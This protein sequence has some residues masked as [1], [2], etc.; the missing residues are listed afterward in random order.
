MRQSVYIESLK[1]VVYLRWAVFFLSLLP[2]TQ[3]TSQD[4]YFQQTVNYTITVQLDD[5]NHSLSAEETIEYINHSDSALPFIWMHL[6]PNAYKDRTSALCKQLL[7]HGNGNLYFSKPEERGFIDSLDFRVNGESV[8]WEYHPDHS[9]ICKIILPLPLKPGERLILSTPFYVKIP[10]ARF[11]RLGHIGQ[12]YFITQWYP[13]PAV[14][15]AKGWH[16][17]PYLDQG[18]FYSEFG[19]FDVSIHL[20]K[21]YV[22]AATGDRADA[23]EEE[24][25]LDQL[26]SKTR[27]LI[28]NKEELKPD[29]KFPPSDTAF[30]TVRFRQNRVHDFAW[31]TDKRY[32]ALR[33]Q[34]E[35]PT[36]GRVVDTWV[37]FTPANIK[38]WKK[39][40]TYVNDAVLFYSRKL[41][42]YPY[43]HA[44]AADG[45]IMAGGGMEYPNITV[46]GTTDNDLMLD[47]TITHEVGHNWFYG[48]L[49]SN[50]RDHPY[51]DEGLNSL[52]EMLYV[53]DKYP[54]K[55][56]AELSGLG[57][58]FPLLGLNKKPYWKDK[59]L[60]Y[61]MS[62]KANLDQPIALASEEFTGFNYGAVVYSK[63]ALVF[64][65]LRDYLG[66]E[67]FDKAMG[68]YY[69][70]YRFK[71]PQPEDLFRSL[72][73]SSG[74]DMSAFEHYFINT[75]S[76]FD[77]KIKKI[78]RDENGAYT[79]VV[80]NK[81]HNPVPF[82][83]YAYKNNQAV[84]LL[85][86]NGFEGKQRIEFPP[87]DADVFK[88]DGDGKLPDLQ[89]RNNT[90]HSKGLFKKR[91]DLKLNLI[92]S[93][94]NEE[95]INLNL[96]GIGGFNY[97]NGV[98]LGVAL[99]NYSV[100]R[101]RFEFYVAPLY[102]FK[103]K[104]LN[105]FADFAFNAF[106]KTGFSSIRVGVK[107]KRFAYDY[108]NPDTYNTTNGTDVQPIYCTYNRIKPYLEFDFKKRK[109][110]SKLNQN[111]QISSTVLFTDSLFYSTSSVPDLKNTNSYMNQLQ[112]TLHNTRY[113]HPYVI[114]AGVWQSASLV[115][116]AV[117]WTQKLSFTQRLVGEIRLFAGAFLSGN[118]E[119]KSYYAFRAGGYAGYQDMLFDHNFI[120][121]NERNGV[122]F[123]QF[124]AEDG[125]LKVWTPLG[126]SSTWLAGINLKTPN[127]IDFPGVLRI[128]LKLY[129]D[130]VVTDKQFLKTD[131]YL[132]DLGLNLSLLNSLVEV[133]FPFA[134]SNDIREALDLNQVE[135]AQRIR[136]TLNIH[137]FSPGKLLQNLIKE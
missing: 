129:F 87:L 14:Y 38:Y 68:A 107:T 116:S 36:S 60:L 104:S 46:I 79:L 120:A 91:R 100:Y 11:S 39:A 135:G 30:K 77:Y 35:L 40:I 102:G 2:F 110:V 73:G 93:L 42:D 33:D 47:V 62:M 132:W 113:L 7:Q 54:D 51:M 8:K 94:E 66:S 97:Y 50:E 123:S 22:L 101:K 9:D 20:P 23:P 80:K 117:S 106:P 82:V 10:S 85:W 75:N 64:D 19:S 92:T 61:F 32:L 136:F 118:T 15:D 31:F 43:N 99:H 5:K 1:K 45:T 137:N 48:I 98:M 124:A 57:P 34:V 12:A 6:W 125:A 52:Y 3:I 88:V 84:A 76:R 90:I 58:N 83:T 86:S 53:R 17:M 49:G 105:G 28:E 112:Y 69:Q 70:A 24:Q 13:K 56:M 122:G 128:P 134:Y 27:E 55:T 133:Y 121:R 111:L 126:Q 29:R 96:L 4:N 74:M 78:K 37:F 109:P 89:V 131:P 25:F 103:S 114:E 16:A 67:R 59:E 71:H 41:G 127:L 81:T 44:T 72:A 63:T 18:E 130:M 26:D 108:F 95:K 21:N 65:Y 115:K 119:A